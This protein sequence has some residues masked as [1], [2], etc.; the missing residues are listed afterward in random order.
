M[1]KQLIALF[2]FA[3]ALAPALVADHHLDG[4]QTVKYEVL[5]SPTHETPPVEGVDASGQGHVELS[6]MRAGGMITGAYV[7]FHVAWRSGV[8]ETLVAMHIHRGAAGVGGGVVVNASL[9]AQV[10][11]TGGTI[12]RQAKVTDPDAL[13]VIK[14]IMADPS[15]FYLNIHSSSQPAGIIR[16]QLQMDTASRL[17][18]TEARLQDSLDQIDSI[19]RQVFSFPARR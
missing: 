2:V 15:G 10:P 4:V 16:G 12:F 11:G 18:N 6:V 19:L 1:K 7:D 3:V 13:E 8:A 5:L 17:A 9:G 14:E